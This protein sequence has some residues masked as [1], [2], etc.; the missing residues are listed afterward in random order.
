MHS[1][2]ARYR[3]LKGLC[4]ARA[5]RLRSAI[6]ERAVLGVSGGVGRHEKALRDHPFSIASQCFE[7]AMRQPRSVSLAG[8]LLRHLR[9]EQDDAAVFDLVLRD[10]ERTVAEGHF[11]PAHGWI[12][13]DAVATCCLPRSSADK[14]SRPVIDGLPRQAELAVSPDERRRIVESRRDR[15]TYSSAAAAWARGTPVL[16]H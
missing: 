5:V 16:G 6:E 11:K 13:P 15:R 10:C 14:V 3:R 9:V 7:N 2:G 1:I 4:R 12:V 8:Q